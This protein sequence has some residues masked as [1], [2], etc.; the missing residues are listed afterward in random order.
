MILFSSTQPES[1][2][3]RSKESRRRFFVVE[4]ESDHRQCHSD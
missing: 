4:K 1:N 2:H 3:C